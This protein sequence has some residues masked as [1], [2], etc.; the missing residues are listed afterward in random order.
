MSLIAL[1]L[2][3]SC[4]SPTIEGSLSPEDRLARIQACNA[5]W[6]DEGFDKV[7]AIQATGRVDQLAFEAL[8]SAKQKRMAEILACRITSGEVRQQRIEFHADGRVLKV[9]TAAN[10]IDFAAE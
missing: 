5:A 7:G 8:G 10:N 4:S 3:S 6:R 9:V 2:A 1:G